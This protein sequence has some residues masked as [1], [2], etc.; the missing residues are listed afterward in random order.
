MASEEY[1]VKIINPVGVRRN[2]LESSKLLLESLKGYQRILDLRDEK[3]ALIETLRRHMQELDL[4]AGK[5]REEL[6]KQ[7]LLALMEEAPGELR[8]ALQ[9][10]LDGKA[11]RDDGVGG[12]A[13]Q[14]LGQEEKEGTAGEEGEGAQKKDKEGAGEK[15]NEGADASPSEGVDWTADNTDG[16][17]AQ[18]KDDAS[19]TQERVDEGAAKSDAVK[20]KDI[21]EALKEVR[22]EIARLD[23]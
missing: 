13:P 17:A 8:D 7:K 9:A 2:I 15:G 5:L 4:L 11:S 12:G 1:Y 20:L 3:F 22:E 6:P 19:R 21:Q 23:G 14:A 10:I 16:A 18:S